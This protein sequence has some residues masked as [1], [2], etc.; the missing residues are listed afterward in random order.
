MDTQRTITDTPPPLHTLDDLGWNGKGNEG[1]CRQA[2]LE[3]SGRSTPDLLRPWQAPSS[4][5]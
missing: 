3:Q 2:Q 5:D 1:V 4:S